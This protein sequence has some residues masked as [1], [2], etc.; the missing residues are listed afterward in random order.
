MAEPTYTD[1]TATFMMKDDTDYTLSNTVLNDICYEGHYGF[2]LTQAGTPLGDECDDGDVTDW[3]DYSTLTDSP[4]VYTFTND[5]LIQNP[6]FESDK[7]TAGGWDEV[8]ADGITGWESDVSWALCNVYWGYRADDGDYFL[9]GG[10]DTYGNGSV[11]QDIDLVAAGFVAAEIDDDNAE[12]VSFSCRRYSESNDEGRILIQ[13]LESDQTTVI[14]DGYDTGMETTA[15]TGGWFTRSCANVAIPATTRYI[16]VTLS[17]N[18]KYGTTCGC[19]FDNLQME[20]GCL[21]VAISAFNRHAFKAESA[22][23]D[24]SANAFWGG[25][26]TSSVHEIW[27]YDDGSPITAYERSVNIIQGGAAPAYSIRAAIG[28]CSTE[29][30]SNYIWWNPAAGGGSAWEDTGIARS[31]GWHTI[32]YRYSKRT[33]GIFPNSYYVWNVQMYHDGT[34]LINVY[35][36]ADDGDP[37][38]GYGRAKSFGVHTQETGKPIY[39][40]RIRGSKSDTHYVATGTVETPKVQPD[41]V[42]TWL[43]I[44]YTEDLGIQWKGSTEYKFQWSTNGGASWNGT[45]IAAT[46]ANLFGVGCD[47]DGDDAIKFQITLTHHEDTLHTPRIRGLT[48]RYDK[49]F[50]SIGWGGVKTHDEVV[51][52]T[53]PKHI[54]VG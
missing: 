28:L 20:V 24:W 45:W 50:S 41:M 13:F 27:W 35:A 11:W 32:R 36:N 46:E 44:T 14:S 48:I 26:G 47:G 22:T 1:N 42:G 49:T 18:H 16:R 29:H 51:G 38:P 19:L 9:S 53:L 8:V 40:D 21:Q 39:I 25:I 10:I 12:I 23:S 5:N 2:I 4:L 17:K 15:V 30:P 52:S 34:R 6:S 37:D 7:V 31:T 43:R 33:V 54:L 3:Y